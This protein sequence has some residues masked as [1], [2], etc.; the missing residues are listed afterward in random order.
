MTTTASIKTIII[1]EASKIKQNE[2]ISKNCQL[3]QI[4][5]NYF[6]KTFIIV[7]LMLKVASKESKDNRFIKLNQQFINIVM[8]RKMTC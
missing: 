7:T 1:D 4:N 5:D 6:K 3:F 8:K 2:N